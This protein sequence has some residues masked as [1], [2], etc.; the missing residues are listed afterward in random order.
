M[1]VRIAG[2]C[3]CGDFPDLASGITNPC[4]TASDFYMCSGDLNS[5]LGPTH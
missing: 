4:A 3:T 5:G 2:L 1:H